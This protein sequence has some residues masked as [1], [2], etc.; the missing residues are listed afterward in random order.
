MSHH[1]HKSVSVTVQNTKEDAVFVH[2]VKDNR[3]Q[4]SVTFTVKTTFF[5]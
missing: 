1:L 2:R 5:I 4:I 3:V